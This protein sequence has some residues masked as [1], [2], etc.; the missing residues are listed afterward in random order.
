MPQA[1][2]YREPSPER[3]RHPRTQLV[4]WQPQQYSQTAHLRRLA[5]LLPDEPA[6]GPQPS[7]RPQ[8]Q[9]RP[10]Q[11]HGQPPYQDP[12]PAYTPGYPRQPQPPAGYYPPQQYAPRPPQHGRHTARNVLAGIGGLIIL[13]IVVSVAANSGHS[14]QTA[15][16]SQGAPPTQAAEPAQPAV[17]AAAVAKMVATFSGTGVQAT[18]PFTVSSTWRLDYSFDCSSFGYA[19]NFIIME[20]GGLAG[21]MD[22]NALAMSKAGSSYAYSDAGQHYIKV[23]SECS[24][25][26][27][28]IDEG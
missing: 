12:Q 24:W 5:P 21:A 15:G 4:P 9:A 27:K 19:G 28:V 1:W 20:D 22:V 26:L 25:T 3:P 14:T 18:P 2:E 10:Q 8:P 16:S 17:K 11:H 13:I 23:D 7:F 6:R